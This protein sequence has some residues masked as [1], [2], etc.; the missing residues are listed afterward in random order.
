MATPKLTGFLIGFILITLAASVFGL[1][2]SNVSKGYS[3]TTNT[4]QSSSLSKYSEKMDNITS[5]AERIRDSTNVDAKTSWTDILGGYFGAAYRTVRI[6]FNSF[7][8]FNQ[9]ADD[10]MDDLAG[11][12]LSNVL[13][14]FKAA[15]YT[16]LLILVFVGIFVAIMVKW[17]TI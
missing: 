2:L 7:G 17:D 5:D 13:S 3:N 4:Y 11:D 9:M 16:I 12:N 8:L 1:Y 15:L 10:S 6:S 14:P